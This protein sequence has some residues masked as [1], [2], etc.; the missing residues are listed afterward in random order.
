MVVVR[1]LISTMKPSRHRYSFFELVHSTIAKSDGGVTESE[2][3]FIE[4]TYCSYVKDVS[5]VAND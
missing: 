4:L 5:S 2:G 3:G 1:S